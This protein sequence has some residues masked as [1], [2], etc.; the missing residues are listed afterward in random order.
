MR[1]AEQDLR[2]I[3]RELGVVA[4]DVVAHAEQ[5]AA[6]EAAADRDSRHAGHERAREFDGSARAQREQARAR[7]KRADSA[8]SGASQV[9]QGRLPDP[10]PD[11]VEQA[12]QARRRSEREAQGRRDEAAKALDT[13]RVEEE[14]A[15]RLEASSKH[16]RTAVRS[17]HGTARVTLAF[18][19]EWA[20]NAR[21]L[22][23]RRPEL[24]AG[25]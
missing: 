8:V 11:D 13:A 21:R 20:D 1:A 17:F 18:L 19:G 14:R 22:L 2:R 9:A 12:E 25:C 5:L 7:L 24:A 23:Q 3:Q 4:A 16:L 15:R 6:D 10:M